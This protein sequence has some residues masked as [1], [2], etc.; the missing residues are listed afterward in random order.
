MYTNGWPVQNEIDFLL[1]QPITIQQSET[2]N[3]TTERG[4][5]VS[6]NFGLKT[7]NVVRL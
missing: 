4:L 1:K 7:K 6:F 3:G 5:D 2:N